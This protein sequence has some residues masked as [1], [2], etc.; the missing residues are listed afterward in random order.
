MTRDKALQIC[1]ESQNLQESEAKKYARA[2]EVFVNLASY[3]DPYVCR[4][5]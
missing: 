1:D 4:D 3:E 5:H 2:V